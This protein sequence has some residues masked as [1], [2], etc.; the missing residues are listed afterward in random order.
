MPGT[1]GDILAAGHGQSGAI[2]APGRPFLGYAGLRRRRG[3]D[4]GGAERRGIGRDDAVAIV[5]PNGPEMAAAFVARLRPRR[6]RRSTRPTW[7]TSSSST[8]PISRPRR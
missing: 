1:M 6:P 8:S 7:P 2:G 4:D 5:L 3:D